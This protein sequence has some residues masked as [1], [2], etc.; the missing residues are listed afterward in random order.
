MPSYPLRPTVQGA[1]KTGW[2]YVKTGLLYIIMI[3]LVAEKIKTEKCAGS[4]DRSSQHELTKNKPHVPLALGLCA[5]CM[6]LLVCYSSL[7]YRQ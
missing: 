2:L 6:T 7:V 4:G 5:L 3:T 1:C